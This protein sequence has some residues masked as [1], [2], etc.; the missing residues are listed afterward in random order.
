MLEEKDDLIDRD[1]RHWLGSLRFLSHDF[2]TIIV[3]DF[4][5]AVDL[6]CEVTR[7]ILLDDW[8]DEL[9]IFNVIKTGSAA[10]KNAD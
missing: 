4:F 1:F 9:G 10:E 6:R 2:D 3:P 5:P 7:R 8:S